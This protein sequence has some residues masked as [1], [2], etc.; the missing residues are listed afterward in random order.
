MI[1]NLELFLKE[2]NTLLE[3]LTDY[4]EATTRLN[5]I[6]LHADLSVEELVF[7]VDD[8]DDIIQERE[9]I[10]ERAE[11]AQTEMTKVI[12]EQS[13][14]DAEL[15]KCVFGGK[16][17]EYSLTGDRKLAKEVIYKLL[18]MQKEIIEKDTEIITK[19][20][21]KQDE[22]KTILKELQ[23]DKKKLDF[24]SLTATGSQDSSGFNV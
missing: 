23:G 17:I 14:E 16:E 2:A 8:I 9:E 19:F 10:K 11:I 22:I 12:E 1:N 6:D 3:A 21:S 18:V 7:A 15:I 4:D 13:D 20:S 24:L 5:G